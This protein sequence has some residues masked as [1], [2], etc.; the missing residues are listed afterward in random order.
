MR[1]A[2][3]DCQAE[4][5]YLRS[6]SVYCIDRTCANS[7]GGLT[8]PQGQRQMIW[9]CRACSPLCVVETWRRPGD[10]LRWQRVKATGTRA[11]P[12]VRP[13]VRSAA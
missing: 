3:P 5:L 10:Q 2:N 7:A 8:D 6:G 12:E 1:C 9:V 4:A 13:I 11:M